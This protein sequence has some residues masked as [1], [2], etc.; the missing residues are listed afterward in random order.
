MGFGA[1][2]YLTAIHEPASK[3]AVVAEVRKLLELLG[4]TDPAL[5]EELSTGGINRRELAELAMW[6]ER[7]ARNSHRDR[8]GHAGCRFWAAQA[9]ATTVLRA[10]ALDLNAEY[11]PG[12]TRAMEAAAD[13]VFDVG[14]SQFD[15]LGWVADELVKWISAQ[16]LYAFAI[17][18]SPLGNSLPVQVVCDAAARQGL[19]PM[20]VEWNAPRND[21][22]SRGRVIADAV[23][24]CADA[25]A[26]FPLV[27]FMDDAITGTRFVKLF[28][29][30]IECIGRDR[31]LPIAMVFED[32][33]RPE[34]SVDQNLERL[35][36]RVDQQGACLG[37][38]KPVI[39]FPQQRFFKI[40]DGNHVRWQ[41]PLIWGDRISSR[42]NA[43]SISCSPF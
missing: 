2:L 33:F 1:S 42:E 23:H 41:S 26:E 3:D 22:P 32:S 38:P 9:L 10:S 18:E 20:R 37:Y 13:G 29:A 34:T 24:E 14:R 6:N 4:E 25:T 7:L 12:I 8:L 11:S 15:A 35:M 21:K 17:I 39:R 16:G 43:R 28:D 27:V 5:A 36:R 19:V 30:L 40:D 31:F